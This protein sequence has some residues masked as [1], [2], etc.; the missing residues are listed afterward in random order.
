MAKGFG[1]AALA[2][3][4]YASGPVW[5]TEAYRQDLT[6]QVVLTW[7]FLIAA[8]VSWLLIAAVPRFRSQFRRVSRRSLIELLALGAL[9][10]ANA[11]SFYASLTLI[12][13]ALAVV[14]SHLSPAIIFM[15]SRRFGQ[16]LRGYR[17]VGAVAL[18]TIGAMLSVG[19]V[20]GGANPVGVGLALFSTGVY[21]IWAMLVSR[22]GGER[23]DA[24]VE[25]IEVFPATTI[26]FTGT[27]VVFLLLTTGLGG[28]PE[29]LAV[30]MTTWSLL[31]GFALVAS[32]LALQAWYAS[33]GLIGVARTAI[34]A[35][36]EPFVAML[37]ALW[38]LSQQVT[39]LQIAGAALVVAAAV[40]VH[41]MPTRAAPIVN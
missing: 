20:A 10:V 4:A 16:G 24:R 9:F 5:A 17:A 28:I 12:P 29:L 33:A 32:I 11:A 23:K 2:A 37:L 13:V 34:V 40:M 3:A 25:G 27:A 38:F 22:Q 8:A 36:V 6:W 31:V 15:L 1:L 14:L 41:S 26:M 19:G 39:S 18:A 7:R 35:T 21:A 30:E